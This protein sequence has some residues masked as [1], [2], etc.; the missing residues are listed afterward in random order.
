M[1]ALK[2]MPV[3]FPGLFG[4]WEMTMDPIAI[5]VG[6]GIY[7]YGIILAV[8]MLAGLFLCMKLA[9]KYGLT[10]DHAMDVALWSVP[11]C[12]VGAR[13][14]Y[15][16][17]YLDMY[18]NADGSLNWGNMIAV[19][20][21]GLAIY[22]S[23]IMALIVVGVYTHIKKIPYLAM[24]DLGAQG[25]LLGQ[26]IGRWANFVNR[27]A[28]GAETTLPWRMK[29]W[30]SQYQSVEVHPTF[31]YESLWN[32]VGLLLI[33][34]VVSK[35]RRFDG[36]NT[37]FYLLWYGLG[38][39]W[40]EGL[41]T[42]SLYLFNWELMGEPI[43]VSQALS[44]VLVLVAVGMMFYHIKIKKRTSETLWVNR[45]AAEEARLATVAAE[46][47]AMVD[48]VLT[49]PA[50]ESTEEVPEEEAHGNTD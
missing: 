39:T 2:N 9:P 50:A 34:F 43:R 20:D 28:F 8:G 40:I 1:T 21:G 32:L 4:D 12:I 18:R 15:V 44:M 22:G 27:E 47:K 7:W 24:T 3:S 23:V 38:R 16:L 36:E 37:C 11:F 26:I 35:A 46:E 25:L 29:L 5:H 41:R 6:H 48:A 42:D 14:Y 49:E 31:L 10:E 45:M 17:F 19:W 33:L 30:V 13:L